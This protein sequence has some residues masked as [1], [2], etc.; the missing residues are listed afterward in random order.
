M[1][2]EL[3][4]IT[5]TIGREE[6]VTLEDETLIKNPSEVIEK[7]ELSKVKSCVP[8]LLAIAERR[9]TLE[10]PLALISKLMASPAD[11]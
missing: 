3:Y 4:E 2:T 11:L 1:G 9:L 10:I 8:Y 6:D 5:I 7:K